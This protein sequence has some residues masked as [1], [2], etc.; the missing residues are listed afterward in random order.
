MPEKCLGKLVLHSKFRD[1][2]QNVNCR[3]DESQHAGFV[4]RAGPINNPEKD[5]PQTM[6]FGGDKNPCS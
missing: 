1:G 5:V 3:N 6:N 4:E 2:T